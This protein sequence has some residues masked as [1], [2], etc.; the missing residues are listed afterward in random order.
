MGTLA[1][2]TVGGIV[3]TVFYFNTAFDRQLLDQVQQENTDLR[4]VNQSFEGTIRDLE[5][6]LA[7]FQQRIHKLAIVAGVSEL[8]P[9]SDAGIG[10]P[11][12]G[13]MG[14]EL[15]Q[16]E[17]HAH[18][19]D[20]GLNLLQQRFAEQALLISSMPA[21][22]PVKGILTSRFGYR[23]DPFTKRRA[24]HN[25]IDIVAPR[26]KEV[27]A[28]GD[29][30]VMKAGRVQGLGNAVYLSHGYGL[31]TRYG[32]LWRIAVK[33]GQKVRRGDVVGYVGNSGRSSG[34]H[35]HYEVRDAGRPSNPLGYILDST[36]P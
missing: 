15:F 36:S 33:A 14:D 21:V 9:T 7:D 26:G 12:E 17:N 24:F 27:K 29:G 20:Q 34:Y 16:L 13:G 28:T 23:H 2:L 25:G 19:L 8:S 35:L 18:R 22:A 3:A 5:T 11:G 4:E 30:V 32:H 10:G 31:T 6:Q 1:V